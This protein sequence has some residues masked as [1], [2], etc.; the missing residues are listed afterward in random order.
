[1]TQPVGPRNARL[2]RD[3]LVPWMCAVVAVSGCKEPSST[4]T[5]VPACTIIDAQEDVTVM[6]VSPADVEPDSAETGPSP[7][8]LDKESIRLHLVTARCQ[9]EAA[10]AG[11]PFDLEF[12]IANAATPVPAGVT[13]DSKYVIACEQALRTATWVH[14]DERRADA[15]RLVVRST[16][17]LGGA[18]GWDGDCAEGVCV[19][20]NALNNECSYRC[21]QIG[22][23]GDYCVENNACADWLACIN[24][25]CAPARSGQLGDQCVP[26]RENGNTNPDTEGCRHGLICSQESRKC[27]PAGK[28]GETC[29]W[30]GWAYGGYRSTCS[31]GLV[32]WTGNSKCATPLPEN[33]DCNEDEGPP[34]TPRCGHDLFC[35]GSGSSK[36]CNPRIR[37]G[38]GESCSTEVQ[39]SGSLGLQCIGTGTQATCQP[40]PRLGQACTADTGCV[41]ELTCQ[42]GKCR[43][44]ELGESCAENCGSNLLCRGGKC[45]PLGGIG[46]DC[47]GAWE[48]TAPMYCDMLSKCRALEFCGF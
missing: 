26:L 20:L 34:G 18:C 7:D 10:I 15:C 33:A 22:Q 46:D 4:G 42:E 29:S 37:A 47:V 23:V 45:V 24:K 43:S 32:C 21:V 12:C 25:K 13:Y 16:Q 19:R 28:I 17:P 38:L 1:M 3:A 48:C 41:G 39:C 30:V 27:V 44:F 36:T 9:G 6:D 2:L 31:D 40:I 11:R 8:G 5:S 35:L 14:D